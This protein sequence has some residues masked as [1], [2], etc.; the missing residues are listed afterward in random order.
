MNNTS[1][2]QKVDAIR[3]AIYEETKDM[4]TQQRKEY[5]EKNTDPIILKY[6]FKLIPN[7]GSNIH[8]K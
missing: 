1:V 8:F 4:T 5:L 7:N 2:E 3:R 6:G